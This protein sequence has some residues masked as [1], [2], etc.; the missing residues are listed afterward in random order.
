MKRACVLAVVA[1]LS[2]PAARARA[3]ASGSSATST[4]V[5]GRT[6]EWPWMATFT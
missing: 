5:M 2:A 1:A 6:G 4:M 3:C